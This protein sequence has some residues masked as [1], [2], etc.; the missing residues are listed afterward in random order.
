MYNLE[1]GLTLLLMV[2]GE[3]L[4]NKPTLMLGSSTPMLHQTD[5]QIHRQFS[6]NMNSEKKRA[7]EQ[8]IREIEHASFCPL[9]LAATGGLA[10]EA[11]KDLPPCSPPNWTK[12]IVVLYVSYD[13]VSLFSSYVHLYKQSEG[14]DH[15]VGT[16][17]D[18]HGTVIDL[19]T[20]EACLQP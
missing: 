17:F 1:P 10:R 13:A 3:A 11:T 16:L 19:S 14:Q 7:Y 12:P 20:S 18:L 2:Y 4:S 8:R 6:E 5:M 9:V 15:P